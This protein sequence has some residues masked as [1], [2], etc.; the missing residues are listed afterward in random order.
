M[1]MTKTNGFTIGE[2]LYIEQLSMICNIEREMGSGTQGK[3]YSLI[4]PD[5]STLVL[6]WYFPSMATKE[7]REIINYLIQTKPPSDRFLWPIALVE[8]PKREGFGYV[9]PLKENRFKSFSS[10][11]S[12]KVDP[13][14]RI[15]LTACFELAQNFHLMHSKGLCYQDL[16]LNN[17]Y[18]DPHN[19]EIRIGDTDNIVINGSGKGNV[20]GTPKF[21]APE[22]IVGK[23]SPNTQTDL[24]SLAV[25]L[26]YILFLNH[27]LEGKAESSIRSLDIPSMTKLYGFNPVFIFDPEDDSNFPDPIYHRNALIYWNIYP[28]FFKKQFIKSFTK[29]I[30]DPLEGRVRETEWQIALLELRDSIFYCKLCGSENFLD[31]YLVGA[32]SLGN[33][34]AY[35][36]KSQNEM[37]SAVLCELNRSVK[38]HIP[39]CWN[40]NCKTANHKVMYIQLNG[41]SIVTLNHDTQLFLHH[42]DPSCKYNFSYIIA[43]VNRHPR[44]DQVWGLKNLSDFNW[45]VT[46]P[47]SDSI[48]VLPKQS[49]LIAPNTTI[50]FGKSI[51]TIYYLDEM[52]TYAYN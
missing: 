45:N 15:L 11:L 17:I 14:F 8:S 26:F 3:V 37:K 49:V 35:S 29:G 43:E 5:N 40:H 10:W 27:P 25:L 28:E 21:M 9:M 13:S 30:N 47:N 16:S 31:P 44:N 38:N 42:V 23:E 12:R 46:K 24:Y 2:T 22:I 51:G 19:G 41:R 32:L 1:E 6:K 20:L 34:D 18:F 39:T 7:Q 48:K 4:C 52:I 50:D 36:N 33:V